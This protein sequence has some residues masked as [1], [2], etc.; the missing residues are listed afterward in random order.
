MNQIEISGCSIIQ[1][2][3]I[4][5]K[6]SDKKIPSGKI[7]ISFKQ[8]IEAGKCH[9]LWFGGELASIT[10]GGYTFYISAAGRVIISLLSKKDSHIIGEVSDKFENG[11]FANKMSCYIENDAMIERLLEGTDSKYVLNVDDSNYFDMT[12]VDKN[13]KYHSGFEN[14]DSEHIFDAVA[15]VV[16]IMQDMI[17]ELESE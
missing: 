8:L 5:H 10:Y 9:C 1:E 6:L 13:K 17:A 4:R 15:E 14:L 16:E 7:Q 3:L 11:V 2:V 12:I